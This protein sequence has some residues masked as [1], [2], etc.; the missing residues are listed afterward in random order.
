MLCVPVQGEEAE[1]RGFKIVHAAP[2]K[3]KEQSVSRS[4]RLHPSGNIFCHFQH[5]EG[6]QLQTQPS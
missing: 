2:D 3:K 6:E 4:R 1:P 5:F